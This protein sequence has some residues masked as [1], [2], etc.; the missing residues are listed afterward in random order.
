MGATKH[1]TRRKSAALIAQIA[2]TGE[3][4][5]AGPSDFHQA[6]VGNGPI[7]HVHL[8]T[9]ERADTF[10]VARM[11]EQAIY[12][13]MPFVGAAGALPVHISEQH[14]ELGT[15]LRFFAQVDVYQERQR[16]VRC[17]PVWT[18]ATAQ[19]APSAICRA[20]R[21]TERSRRAAT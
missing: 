1:A 5:H 13:A 19:L 4:A 20:W 12:G 6:V 15:D 10:V 7:Q 11:P 9:F 21:R 2:E 14:V 18:V 16:V 17:P 3:I 8:I